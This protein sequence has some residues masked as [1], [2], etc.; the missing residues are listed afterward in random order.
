MSIFSFRGRSMR[1][2]VLLS[3]V[4]G[5]VATCASLPRQA[6]AQVEA[7]EAE[8]TDEDG[9]E[10]DTVA[11]VAVSSYNSLVADINFLG[12]LAD[13]P[14]AGQ[15]LEGTL[16][17]FTQGKGL[18]GLD[19]TKSWGIVLQTD[20]EQFLPVA[21][22]P[23]TDLEAVLGIVRG[24]GIQ[25]DDG[26]DGAKKIALP[27]GET[28]HVTEDEG[29]AYISRSVDALDAL[30]E[31]PEALFNELTTNY[32]IGV[33][34]TV[35][36]VPEPYRQ[37]AIQAM[38]S[39]MEQ[40]LQRKEGEDDQS[41]EARR[42]MAEAQMAQVERMVTEIDDVTAGWT[43]DAEG[44]RT[45]LDF[46]YKFVPDS[47]MAKQI[48]SYG[49]PHTNFA[50]FFQPSAAVTANFATQADPKQIQPEDL[51][52]MRAMVTT[53]RKQAEKAIDEDA[54]IPDD[55]TRATLKAA[56]GDFLDAAQAT[57]ESGQLDGGAALNLRPD[58]LT[59]VAAMQ[60]KEPAK[61]ES[62]LKKLSTIA[63]KEPNFSG[64][65]WNATN[66]AGVNFHTLSVPVPEDK[67]EA[68]KLLGD[69]VDVAIGLGTNA[70]YV[71]VGRDNINA[72]NQAI[73]ASK[74]EPN[75]AIPPFQLAVS[76]GP[77][78][79]TAAANAKDEDR[80]MVQAIADML[81]RDA[82]GRDHVRVVGKMIE[83]GLQ[84][85]IEA[86]EGVLRAIG[87]ASVMAQ[88]KAAQ[89]VQAGQH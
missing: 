12:S 44:K 53:M 76:L 65:K 49:Q 15:M 25:I 38:K 46:V 58:S 63:E 50:G 69:K 9:S 40:G 2:A 19:K 89:Q 77:I 71:A 26:E 42:K 32:D 67:P 72:V 59:L 11:V 75:K 56:V 47:K 85:R 79:A 18:V 73:D 45:F 62:G 7:P 29:W 51:D 41:Y 28:I 27:N 83:N 64:I 86:E 21:C 60:V 13:R 88:Q 4:L 37:L 43:I 1:L 34:I 24:F 66:H 23:V 3:I 31:D 10:I 70:V 39:G 36:N 84:Y 8:A 78:M 55:A 16:A 54:D 17:L 61:I 35:Q 30:P 74:A 33:H 22:L 81:Q 48:A 68:R 52:Q 87:K 14:Q 57:V 80:A 82:A 20:G 5:S 6:F